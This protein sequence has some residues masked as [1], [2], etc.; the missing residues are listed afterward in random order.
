MDNKIEKTNAEKMYT[1]WRS[2]MNE[3]GRRFVLWE[4]LSETEK[5]PW[6]RLAEKYK[7]VE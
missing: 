6:I 7:E 5:A 4:Q 1:E 2:L 3:Y